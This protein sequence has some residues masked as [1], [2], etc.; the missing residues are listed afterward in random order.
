MSWFSEQDPELTGG[1][2]GGQMFYPSEAAPVDPNAPD[3]FAY[4]GGS[5]LTPWTRAFDSSA[6]GGGGYGAPNVDPFKY[7]DFNY[8]YKAPEA[9]GET[10]TSANPF[11]YGDFKQPTAADMQVD[12]GYQFRLDQGQKSLERSAAAK[13]VLRTGGTLKDVQNL[14]Q[15]YASD[16][17]G[18]VFSRA[19]TGYNTNRGNAAENFDRNEANRRG[20][21]DAR[22]GAWRQNADV[23][24]AGQNLGFNVAT[25]T[26]DRNRSN[27]RQSWEDALS[28]ENQRISAGAAN[29]NQ[30][31]G[32]ALGDYERAQNDFYT[33]QDRQFSK[34]YSMAGLGL[35]GASQAGAYGANNATNAG[36]LITGA[37]NAKAA[38]QVGSANAW[39]SALGNVGNW[40]SSLS[41]YNSPRGIQASQGYYPQDYGSGTLSGQVRY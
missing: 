7:S 6:F 16:E 26:Y 35:Q 19:L 1:G 3:P 8:N 40:A 14:G 21:F 10:F 20:G 12:P 33:N 29:A 13:G 17:Y 25:G 31:Y 18:N 34:L 23:N 36:N 30:S 2:S 24:L 39:N 4:S 9:F 11:S 22:L 28:L 32:R 41:M 37:G 15:K 27:A 5:L 38:G